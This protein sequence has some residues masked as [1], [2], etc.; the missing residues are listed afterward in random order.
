MDEGVLITE[1]ELRGLAAGDARNLHWSTDSAAELMPV[2]RVL[3]A[4]GVEVVLGVEEAVAQIL[5]EIAVEL[6]AARLG[7]DVDHRARALAEFGVV[8]AG[9]DAEFLG[10]IRH[11]VRIVHVG[12]FVQVVAAVEQEIVLIGQCP[13]Y[14]GD[15]NGAEQSAGE[16]FSAT[17]V[18]SVALIG[19]IDY[20]GDERD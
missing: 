8:V 20:A 17:L 2:Q 12:H 18:D 1:E 10:S 15:L 5:E 16:C 19:G 3:R 7:D 9:L 6:F 14:G 11:R 4:D 13:V